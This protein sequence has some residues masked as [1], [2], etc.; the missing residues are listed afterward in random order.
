MRYLDPKNDLVFKGI[1]GQYPNITKS[2]LNSFLLL[3]YDLKNSLQ[4]VHYSEK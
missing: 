3:E 1:F 2:F 4:N